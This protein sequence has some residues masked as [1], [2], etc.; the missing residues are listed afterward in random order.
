MAVAKCLLRRGFLEDLACWVHGSQRP[1]QLHNA[2]LY[3]GAYPN[4]IILCRR[5]RAEWHDIFRRTLP[6]RVPALVIHISFPDTL[7]MLLRPLAV[8]HS[9]NQ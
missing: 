1:M 7:D 2:H 6:A 3:Y 5:R 9:V 4:Y 8:N